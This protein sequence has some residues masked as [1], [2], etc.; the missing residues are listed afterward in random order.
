LPSTAEG[1]RRWWRKGRL[2]LGR[3]LGGLRDGVIDWEIMV[4]MMCHEVISYETEC[5][6]R[7]RNFSIGYDSSRAAFN[8][9]WLGDITMYTAPFISSKRSYSQERGRAISRSSPPRYALLRRRAVLYLI[10]M[11]GLALRIQSFTSSCPCH[12]PCPPCFR[13][14][15]SHWL[16]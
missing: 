3:L 9:A 15:F 16:R 10:M 7:E 14:L 2:T 12:L 8:V 4:I 6:Q 11:P 1:L 5:L 13:R